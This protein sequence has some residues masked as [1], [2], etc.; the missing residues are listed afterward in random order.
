[1]F[2]GS[3]LLGACVMLPG[4]SGEHPTAEN[5]IRSR[6][7]TR[8]SLQVATCFGPHY[9]VKSCSVMAGDSHGNGFWQDSS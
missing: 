3:I 2:F 7:G 9:G 4:G 8:V 1:M 6:V 5:S